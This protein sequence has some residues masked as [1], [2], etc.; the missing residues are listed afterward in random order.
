M[1]SCIPQ[2]AEAFFQ[3]DLM[4]IG[5]PVEAEEVKVW[6]SWSIAYAIGSLIVFSEGKAG[7]ISILI[8]VKEYVR[9]VIFI[10]TSDSAVLLG[11]LWL[12]THSR[13]HL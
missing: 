2:S 6:L 8:R 3:F 1:D 4:W 12:L 5:V 11:R 7:P 13:A 9:A 10:L